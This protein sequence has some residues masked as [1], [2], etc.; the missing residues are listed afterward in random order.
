MERYHK[1][2]DVSKQLDSLRTINSMNLDANEVERVISEH[3][4][5]K[6]DRCDKVFKSLQE[7]QFHYMDEHQIANGY[8]K[9]CGLVFRKTVNINGHILWHL[10]PGMFR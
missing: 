7:A 1:S 3:F 4:D 2:G 8:I 5:M 6:C 9:C 10:N